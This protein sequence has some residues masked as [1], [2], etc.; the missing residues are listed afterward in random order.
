MSSELGPQWD[1]AEPERKIVKAAAGR[2]PEVEKEMVLY[3]MLGCAE[4]HTSNI[5]FVV[6]ESM[7]KSL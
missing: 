4:K 1:Y 2:I 7:K 3:W 5:L 6:I